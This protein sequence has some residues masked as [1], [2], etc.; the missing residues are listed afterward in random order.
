MQ[1][2]Y[3]IS[4]YIFPVNEIY[5]QISLDKFYEWHNQIKGYQLDIITNGNKFISRREIYFILFG[6]LTRDMQFIVDVYSLKKRGKDFVEKILKDNSK[7]KFVHGGLRIY[8]DIKYLYNVEI[9]NIYDTRLML[10]VIL[11]EQKTNDIFELK[12]SIFY[13]LKQKAEFFEKK[14]EINSLTTK[15][16][17]LAS[18]NVRYLFILYLFFKNQKN[19]QWYENVITLENKALRAFGDIMCNGFQFDVKS[20]KKNI[21]IITKEYQE[22]KKEFETY[23][24][25][26]YYDECVKKGFIINENSVLIKW[27]SREQ[28][29]KLF[30]KLYPDIINFTKPALKK[31]ELSLKEDENVLY[32]YV[33]GEIEKLNRFLIENHLDILKENNWYLEKES[34]IINF[35]SPGQTLE[36][37]HLENPELTS[38]SIKKLNP[39]MGKLVSLY[40]RFI[41]K[42]N[43]I[44]SY[45]EDWLNHVE[46]DGRIRVKQI[47]QIVSTGRST[48]MDPPIMTLKSNQK[49][50]KIQYHKSFQARE[51]FEIVKGDYNS[52]ELGIVAYLAQ[53]KSWLKI[54][55]ER[56]DLHSFC[57]GTI[58]KDQWINSGG[59]PTYKQKPTTS[60]AIRLRKLFKTINFQLIFGGGYKNLADKLEIEPAK[61]KKLLEKYFQTFPNVKKYLDTQ[62]KFSL[63]HG[64]ALTAAPFYRKRN[65]IEWNKNLRLRSAEAA[66]IQRKA[67]NTP[68]QGTAADAIKWALVKI[69]EYIKKNNLQDVVKINFVL[70][71]EIITECKKSISE[72]WMKIL[73]KIMMEAHAVNVPGNIISVEM[74]K[75][76]FWVK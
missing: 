40:I 53:E 44:K 71:D 38:S 46:E 67:K 49:D 8:P 60:E 73:E 33:N 45:G 22:I 61:A 19:Y 2:I 12:N 76:K 69:K 24:K 4:D 16:I 64:Y 15:Q 20:W 29:E 6:D 30:K 43:S 13:F 26:N 27:T 23:L 66:S 39:S 21:E 65:F 37:L 52:Q 51:G 5:Q 70:Y 74:K 59:D 31:Y 41:K 68:V 56:K 55:K 75:A 17:W 18:N 72:S 35:N 34:L 10:Q 42:F 11:N 63:A 32:Y 57:A 50:D 48:L 1:K 54:L 58:L 25:S 9:D 28:R 14:I 47:N 7:K 62:T 36:L 3:I